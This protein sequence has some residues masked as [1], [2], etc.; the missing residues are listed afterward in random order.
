M[1]RRGFNDD[2]IM[3]SAICCWIKDT[4]LV[5]NKRDLAYKMAFLNSMSKSTSM[6]DTKISGQRNHRKTQLE[7][8]IENREKHK[9]LI[10]FGWVLKG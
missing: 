2:L 1:A 4:A 8:K 9:E 6:F 7:K 10:D 3:A 5:V